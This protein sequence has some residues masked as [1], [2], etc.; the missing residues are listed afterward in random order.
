MPERK[1]GI[2]KKSGEGGAGTGTEESETSRGEVVGHKVAVV[3]E[4]TTATGT[5]SFGSAV[6]RGPFDDIDGHVECGSR[7]GI[8]SRDNSFRSARVWSRP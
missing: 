4:R 6:L 2:A 1:T 7:Y 8:W 3:F 5:A